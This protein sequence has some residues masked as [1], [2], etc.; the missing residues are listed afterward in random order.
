M[1]GRLGR[2]CADATCDWVGGSRSSE[3]NIM[4]GTIGYSPAL[5]VV[6]VAGTD[7]LLSRRCTSEISPGGVCLRVWCVGILRLRL[8]FGR[9]CLVL[10]CRLLLWRLMVGLVL[11]N[12]CLVSRV[13]MWILV[14][15]MLRTLGL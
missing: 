13:L 9:L 12:G 1:V 7:P 2:G 10:L 4:L 15:L 3:V 14:R 6:V 8:W 5:K 11:V